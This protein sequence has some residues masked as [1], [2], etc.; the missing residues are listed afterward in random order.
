MGYF[1]YSGR[2]VSDNQ[3]FDGNLF[4]DRPKWGAFMYKAID[5]YDHTTPN[6]FAMAM[7]YGKIKIGN[8]VSITPNAGFVIE[9]LESIADSDSGFGA[10]ITSQVKASSH[11]SLEHTAIFSN[12][13]LSHAGKDW[14]NRFRI[15]FD[16]GHYNITWAGWHNN[17]FWDN[18]YY[19]STGITAS[20]NKIPVSSK[21]KLNTSI[22]GFKMIETSD[23]E[24]NPKKD[25]LLLTIA[26]L[27][28]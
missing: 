16:S 26:L 9:Q 15:I 25:G 22:T 24:A 8:R 5:L 2:V 13:A 28:N 17:N 11:L 18:S 10:I 23:E 21:L 6:N 19:C 20:Y 27:I 4:Y 12:L 7:I 3:S 1:G 14:I